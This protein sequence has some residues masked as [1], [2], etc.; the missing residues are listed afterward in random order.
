VV[1]PPGDAAAGAIS[2]RDRLLRALRAEPVD[3]PPVWFMRQAGRHLPGYRA[4]RERHSFLDLCR[5]PGLCAAASCEPWGRYG[6][7]GVIVFNDILIPLRDMGMKL[8]FSPGPRFGAL[9]RGD[10]D[11]HA[12]SEPEYGPGTDVARCLREIRAR[13]GERAALLGFIGAPFTVASFAIAGM[14]SQRAAGLDA[15]VAERAGL[16]E[17]VQERLTGTLVEYA[18][19]QAAAGADVIQVFESLAGEVTPERYRQRGLS[20]LVR[21]VRQLALRLPAVPVIVFGRGLGAFVAEIAGAG[22]GCISLDETQDP[23]SVRRK[24]RG[25]GRRTALQGNLPPSV[26]LLGEGEARAAA[27]RLLSRWREI[28]P[29]AA[30]GPTGWVVNLGHGV[31]AGADPAAVLAVADEVRGFN[32]ASG[33]GEGARA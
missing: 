17:D 20:A 21:T 18:A 6:V 13:I 16:F 12:L 14:S 19:A 30:R 8:D 7:D 3:R 15:L 5:E 33:G 1:A 2:G 9:L 32:E 4:L 11:L 24:L 29:D 10:A 28:V 26:L 22:A 27:R 31:P 25:L 23:V